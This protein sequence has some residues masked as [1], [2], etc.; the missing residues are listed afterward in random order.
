M[1]YTEGGGNEKDGG[2]RQR[3]T[4]IEIENKGFDRFKYLAGCLPRD[5]FNNQTT[6]QVLFISRT[7]LS[8][9]Q[10]LHCNNSNVST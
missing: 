8:T 4:D 1:R 9:G 5:F 3:E 7:M 6:C 10:K 2:G